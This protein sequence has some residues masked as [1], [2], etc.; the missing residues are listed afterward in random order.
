MPAGLGVLTRPLDDPGRL[1]D[2]LPD[3]RALCW[4]RGSDGLVGW[5]EVARFSAAGPDRFA[6]ADAWWTSFTDRMEIKD[7]V[8]LPGSGPVAFASFTFADTSPGSVLVVP[9]V[10]VGRRDGQSWITEFS[11][12]DGPSAVRAV[13]PVRPSTNL[14]YADGLLPVEGYRSAVAEAVRR[15]RAGTLDKA[16]LA[17]DLLAVDDAPLDARFLLRGLAER[18][19]TCWS[20]AVDGLVGATPELLI[21]RTAGTVQSRVLAGTSWPE[22]AGA[23]DVDALAQQ[24]L[25]S[26]KDRH[27]HA[28]AVDSLADAIRPLCTELHIPADPKVIALRNVSHL[29]TDVDGTLDRRDPATLLQLAAAVHPTAAVG[30]TPRHAAVSLIAE[31]EGMDRGRFTGPTGWVDANGDGELGIALRCAQLDGSVARLFAG[32]GVVADSDP[33]TEV[34]EAAAKMLAVRDALEDGD[35]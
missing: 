14:R 9:R 1:L 4:L 5:G 17:H 7:L 24:L 10:L 26:T 15:M 18:Y 31:L 33:D 25:E 28:L 6:A 19:P 2:L 11:H 16:A 30:G 12:G 3:D 21:R 20:Y 13:E 22:T 29:A 8:G 27:E 35:H 32:C 23:S 34:R